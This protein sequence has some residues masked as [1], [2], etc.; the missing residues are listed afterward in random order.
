MSRK[1]AVKTITAHVVTLELVW[2]DD[3]WLVINEMAKR[4]HLEL[5]DMVD[6][7][8]DDWAALANHEIGNEDVPRRLEMPQSDTRGGQD[9]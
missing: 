3:K 5:A 7:I 2:P 8:L 9:A 4:N 1:R 6:E